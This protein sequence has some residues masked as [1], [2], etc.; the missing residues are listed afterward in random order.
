MSINLTLLPLDESSA[1]EMLWRLY[2]AMV[3][4]LCEG[5]IKVFPDKQML[6]EITTTRPALKEMSKVLQA[7][8]KTLIGTRKHVKVHDTLV[9]EKNRQSD[10]EN[11]NSLLGGCVNRSTI[12]M[13]LKGKK[14]NENN[15]SY[16]IFTNT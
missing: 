6:R 10:I 4:F 15:Y 8:M 12:V 13:K 7:V 9:K 16:N 11:C 14:S 5:E 1:A 2:P 3:S